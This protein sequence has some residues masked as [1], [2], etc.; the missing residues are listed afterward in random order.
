MVDEFLSEHEQGEQLKAWARD[1]WAWVLSGIVVGLGLLGGWQYWQTF[2]STRAESASA[3][4]DEFAKATESADKARAESLYKTL[5]EQYAS[6]PYANQARLLQARYLVETN[7]FAKAEAVLR[8]VVDKTNDAELKLVATLR[9]AR[10]L[11]QEAKA[12]DALALI[13]PSKLGAFAGQAHE[14]RGD[15]YFAKQDVANARTEYK[16]AL[17]ALRTDGADVSVLELKLQDL[18]ADTAPAK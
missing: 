1:N 14:V 2:K 18:G 16:A 17:D 8:E 13:D 5:T 10:V 4:L 7:D 15:A 3:M 12:D 11:I 9:L 6:T